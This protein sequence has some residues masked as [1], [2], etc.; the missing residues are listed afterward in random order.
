MS[1]CYGVFLLVKN[2]FQFGRTGIALKW[3]RG[4]LVIITQVQ[5]TLYL[6]S[7]NSNMVQCFSKAGNRVS[8]C[9]AR[10]L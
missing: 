3:P 9:S 1:R 5:G 10:V 8:F 6:H 4:G 2:P 7:E